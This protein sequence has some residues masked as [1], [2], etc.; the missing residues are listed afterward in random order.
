MIEILVASVRQ[1][2]EGSPLAGRSTGKKVSCFNKIQY[3]E[4]FYSMLLV[5][6]DFTADYLQM[7]ALD[8][9]ISI[10][11]ISYSDLHLYVKRLFLYSR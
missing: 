8:F 3:T 9:H 10:L 6:L 11:L 4:Y 1:A 5:L 2:A 7:S